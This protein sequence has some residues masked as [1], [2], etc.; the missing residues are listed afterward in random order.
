MRRSIAVRTTVISVVC[1]ST[2]VVLLRLQGLVPEHTTL[3][4]GSLGLEIEEGRSEVREV[5]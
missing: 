2:A 5:S 1:G 4:D 3:N